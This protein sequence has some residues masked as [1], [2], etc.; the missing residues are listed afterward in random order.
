MER[1]IAATDWLRELRTDPAPRHHLV[2]FPPGGGSAT[3]YRELARR[4]GPGIAVLGVQYPGRQDRL[5]EPAVPDLHTLA[6]RI[7]AELLPQPVDRLAL[8]GHSMGAT[9]AYETARRLT[10]AGLPLTHLFVSGRPAP[11]FVE[12]GRLHQGPDEG[13]IADLE[14]LATDP[15]SV[16]VLRTEP[17]LA[18]LVLPA[19]R[20]DYQAVET[21]TPGGTDPLPCPITALVSTADPTMTP[22]QGDEWRDFTTGAFR[23]ET[24][25]GGHFYLDEQ[26][27]E[28]AALISSVLAES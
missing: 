15:S 19:V 9:V 25:P 6:D 20:A 27:A 13:L 1:A 3:A 14:R 18:D 5:G 8:F 2:C 24:F 28:V 4:T 12:P 16:A 21:Y 23:R 7:A 10:E 26:V 11:T 17:G 22:E